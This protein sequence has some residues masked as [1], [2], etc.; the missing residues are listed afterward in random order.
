MVCEKCGRE[1]IDVTNM[2][3]WS[4]GI[5]HLIHGGYPESN[6]EKIQ[7]IIGECPKESPEA[8]L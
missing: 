2:Q 4:Q 8:V 3:E 1:L 7:T 5:R 6:T